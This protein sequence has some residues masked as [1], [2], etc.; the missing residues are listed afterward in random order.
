MKN[1]IKFEIFFENQ[2]TTTFSF[3]SLNYIPKEES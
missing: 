1:K 2:L 3:E